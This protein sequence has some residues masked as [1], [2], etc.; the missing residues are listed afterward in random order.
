M[1]IIRNPCAWFRI[2]V[3][4][5]SLSNILKKSL[6]YPRISFVNPTDIGFSVS[7]RY[8]LDIPGMSLGYFGTLIGYFEIS[9]CCVDTIYIELTLIIFQN[10]RCCMKLN[11]PNREVFADPLYMLESNRRYVPFL[12]DSCNIDDQNFC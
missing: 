10:F 3:S 9:C 1:N 7:M 2:I 4:Y 11:H 8:P 6:K 5:K 12:N